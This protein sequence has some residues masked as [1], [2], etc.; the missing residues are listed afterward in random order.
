MVF[1][2]ASTAGISID[3]A[4]FVPQWQMNTPTRGFCWVV[5]PVAAGF[6][7]GFAA[8]ACFLTSC[9]TGAA[10]FVILLFGLGLFGGCFLLFCHFLPPHSTF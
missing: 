5:L 8:G 10:F 1:A 7:A 6:A 4:M 9:F 2:Y 3:P